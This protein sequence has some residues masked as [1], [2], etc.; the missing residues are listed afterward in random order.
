MRALRCIGLGVDG[1]G[2][3]GMY[4]VVV[5]FAAA[6]WAVV[7]VA[8][9]APAPAPAPAPAALLAAVLSAIVVVASL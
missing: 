8:P 3:N 7:P 2:G 5:R 9:E 4:E 1:G 6:D